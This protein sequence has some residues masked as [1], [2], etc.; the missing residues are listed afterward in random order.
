MKTLL[1]MRHA[2][3]SWK[4]SSLKDHERPLN[5]RGKKDAP[6]MGK[7]LHEKELVPQR[8]LCST[9]VR[10]VETEKLLSEAMKFNGES[11]F[12]DGYYMAEPEAYLEKVRELPDE[13]ERVMVIGHNPGLEGLVQILCG[14]V[15][16]L[17]TCAVAH[18]VVPLTSWKDITLDT[19]CQLVDL[20]LVQELR[21]KEEK[22]KAEK[23]SKKKPDKKEKKEKH[24][25]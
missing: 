11:L 10:A 22:K 2:K 14:Q 4:E 23:K 15:E 18:L 3:S 13:M 7:V 21:E 9:A 16:S 12:M 24:K 1:I 25:K 17:P 19:E 6:F 5:K 8:I 20:L